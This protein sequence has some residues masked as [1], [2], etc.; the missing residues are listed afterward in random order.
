MYDRVQ[1]V[2]NECGEKAKW[3]VKSANMLSYVAV[4]IAQK[5]AKSFGTRIITLFTKLI[6]I[7]VKV[8]R[9]RRYITFQMVEFVIY[10]YSQQ[11]QRSRNSPDTIK[12]SSWYIVRRSCPWPQNSQIQ[13]E[14][15]PYSLAISDIVRLPFIASRALFALNDSSYLSLV[16]TIN[17]LLSQKN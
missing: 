4:F 16:E 12:S 17:H 1:N 8:V 5:R 10:M 14:C 11:H 6:K 9:H 15:T 3:Y 7:W 2:E 13:F